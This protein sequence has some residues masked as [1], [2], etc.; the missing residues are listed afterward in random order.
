MEK[1]TTNAIL[2]SDFHLHSK[3]STDGKYSIDILLSLAISN[4]VKSIAITDH[5]NFDELVHYMRRNKLDLRQPF[6][7]INGVMMIPGVEVTCRMPDVLNMKGN[8]T[9]LHLLVYASNIKPNS[10]ISRLMAIKHRNDFLVDFGL[11]EYVAGVHN[12][13]LSEG[14]IKN[15]LILT[16][17]SNPGFSTYNAKDAIEFF[18][19]NN[20]DVPATHKQLDRIISQAPRVQRLN[21]DVNDVI[22]IAHQSGGICIMAHPRTNLD[23]TAFKVE[24]VKS[25]LKSGIDGF[26]IMSNSM[27]NDTY[28]IILDTCKEY[29]PNKELYYTGGSDTHIVDSDN[30]IGKISQGYITQS[31]QLHFLSAI[32]EMETRELSK[33]LNPEVENIIDKYYKLAVEYEN[34]YDNSKNMLTEQKGIK[35]ISFE[36]NKSGELNPE[37][38]KNY[39]DYI[40]AVMQKESFEENDGMDD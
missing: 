10:P 34:A 15:H 21:L 32:N 35:N 6:H 25:L 12:I 2:K 29:A 33:K 17:Q 24:A 1:D 26:E 31:S 37:E 22:K 36:I 19:Q 40:Q 8:T 27:N 16:R 23:R 30:T 39:D 38:F 20:I 18:K 14:L 13:Q 3:G 11:L 28:K 7:M 4:N 5:N 9:K